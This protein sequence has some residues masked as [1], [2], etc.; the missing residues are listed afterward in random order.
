MRSYELLF[1][2]GNC[3]LKYGVQS[4][5]GWGLTIRNEYII[6]GCITQVVYDGLCFRHL[7]K[8]ACANCRNI[9]REAGG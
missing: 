8:R 3:L 2:V 1:G 5:H 9:L 4:L 6:K 7:N